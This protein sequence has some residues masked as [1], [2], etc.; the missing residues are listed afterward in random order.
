MCSYSDHVIP[1]KG[2][3]VSYEVSYFIQ[4]IRSTAV[5]G[6]TGRFRRLWS[7]LS[8][9]LTPLFHCCRELLRHFTQA[10]QILEI[11]EP[12]YIPVRFNTYCLLY[13]SSPSVRVSLFSGIL[14]F[15][16]CFSLLFLFS[17]TVL[18]L[19][20]SSSSS[21]CCFFRAAVHVI[22]LNACAFFFCY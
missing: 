11:K 22:L 7:L 1:V 17:P 15:L 16:P 19:A 18:M 13:T 14:A 9:L 8:R 2:R 21:S 10:F 4:D 12:L 20:F 3:I 6:S 5:P